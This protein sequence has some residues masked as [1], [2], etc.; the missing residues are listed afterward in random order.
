MNIELKIDYFKRI[1]IPL[2]MLYAYY[3][4]IFVY[5]VIRR[6]KEAEEAFLLLP[7]CL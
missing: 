1:D 5:F 3:S 4:S 2:E 6:L 7:D